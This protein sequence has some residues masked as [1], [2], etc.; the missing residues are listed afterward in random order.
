MIYRDDIIDAYILFFGRK[1]ESEEVIQQ[2]IINIKNVSN[3]VQTMLNSVEFNSPACVARLESSEVTEKLVIQAFRLILDRKPESQKVIDKKVNNVKSQRHL[4]LGMVNSK[5]YQR[6][7]ASKKFMASDSFNSKARVIFLHIPKTAGTAFEQLA[8]KNFGNGCSLSTSG[9]FSPEEWKES[10]LI[11]G[12]FF[13]SR[14][15][16]MSGRRLFLGVVRDPVDR[17]ISGFNY[18]K[19]NNSLMEYR[20]AKGFDHDDFLKTIRKSPFRVEFVDNYQCKYLSGR[21]KFSAV[22]KAFEDDAFIIGHYEGIDKW[23]ELV[24]K[25]LG[26]SEL[27]L[28]KVNVATDPFYMN[29]YKED[30]TLIDLL[31]QRNKEDYRLFDYVKQHGVYESFGSDFDYTPFREKYC[32]TN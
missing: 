6:S 16:G 21:Q 28:P 4:V 27:T 13:Y 31:Q 2:K 1:I 24:G 30:K 5:E 25:R 20:K 8:E 19:N 29:Q 10:A 15:D 11:G 18:Y 12:H 26:W 3:M 7:N 9:K 23:L 32:E 14:Y 17:A 22:Q